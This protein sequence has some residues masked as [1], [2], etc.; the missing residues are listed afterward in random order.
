MHSLI[1]RWGI[2]TYFSTLNV[3]LSGERV[4]PLGKVLPEQIGRIYGLS[5]YCDRTDPDEI[6]TITTVQAES[7]YLLMKWGS[8]DFIDKIALTDLIFSFAGSP[9]TNPRRYLPVNI[10]KDFN[11]D[12]SAIINPL[13]FETGRV[14]LNLWYISDAAYATLQQKQQILINGTA[15]RKS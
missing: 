4:E 5:I 2:P 11:L 13:L 1:I 8:S 3:D 6:A 7:L 9:N 15:Q 12:K 10:P 14:M